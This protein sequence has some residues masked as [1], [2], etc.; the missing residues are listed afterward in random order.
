MMLRISIYINRVICTVRRLEP[1][2]YLYTSSCDVEFE[3]DKFDSIG[4]PVCLLLDDVL[5]MNNRIYTTNQQYCTKNVDEVHAPGAPQPV[6]SI[7]VTSRITKRET[8]ISILLDLLSSKFTFCMIAAAS[9]ITIL[10]CNGSH[11]S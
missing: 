3:G 8:G 10:A 1:R 6:A 4:S 2:T 7:E 9:V 11:D 5:C